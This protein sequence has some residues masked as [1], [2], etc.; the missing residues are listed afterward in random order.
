[1][2]A[3]RRWN[4]FF[5]VLGDPSTRPE[6]KS[7]YCWDSGFKES[8]GR[9]KQANCHS[10]SEFVL[11]CILIISLLNTSLSVVF[12]PPAPVWAGP[13]ERIRREDDR[14]SV[15]QQGTAPLKCFLVLT[16][17]TVSHRLSHLRPQSLNCQ[18]LGIESR[19]GG[20][21][22]AGPTQSFLSQQRQVA[23]APRRAVSVNTPASTSN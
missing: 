4:P 6:T 10:G 17:V 22:S 9:A 15:V 8:A 20:C 21:T 14:H 5:F 1:M 18:R 23:N 16:S 3:D 2:P 7:S 11:S 12:K 13:A 19:L